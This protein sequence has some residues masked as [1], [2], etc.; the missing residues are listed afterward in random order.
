MKFGTRWPPVPAGIL[1]GVSML[2]A[3]VVAERVCRCKSGA[4]SYAAI[5]AI[6]TNCATWDSKRNSE[7]T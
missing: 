1:I 3:F 4:Y 2:L 5:V 6:V 7:K